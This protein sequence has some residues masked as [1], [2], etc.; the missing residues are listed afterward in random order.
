MSGLSGGGIE[1][2]DSGEKRLNM[3]DILN[4]RP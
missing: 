4:E 2:I 3:K 1:F